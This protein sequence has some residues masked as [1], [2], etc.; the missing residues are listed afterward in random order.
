MSDRSASGKAPRADGRNDLATE[1]KKRELFT[2]L[3]EHFKVLATE[4][5][6]ALPGQHDGLPGLKAEEPLLRDPSS[7]R[8]TSGADLHLCFPRPREASKAAFTFPR[9]QRSSGA[10]PITA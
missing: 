7:A 3:A 10:R 2:R 4:L 1:P 6:R 9:S 8:H 5:E